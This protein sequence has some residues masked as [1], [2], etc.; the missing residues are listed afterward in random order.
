MLIIND[1]KKSYKI[2]KGVYEIALKGISCEFKPGFNVILGPSGCGKSTLLNIISG[3]DS[4]YEG[5]VT[6]GNQ[7]LKDINLNA[8]RKEAVGFVFQNFNLV[9]HLTVLDN[10]KAALYLNGKLSESQRTEMAMKSLKSLHMDKFAR[11]HPN[12]LSGGQKQ[13]VAI[14]RALAN[15]PGIILADEPTGAL[16]SKI[17][18]D[19]LK[20]LTDLAASGKTVIIVTHDNSMVEHADSVIRLLDGNIIEYIKNKKAYKMNEFKFSKKTGVA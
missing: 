20:I 15:D 4:D 11:K 19:V 16:D 6:F 7:K 1:I 3:L 5:T 14:A 18:K 2:D 10:V 17:G 9:G 13:R 12:Q 8:Y